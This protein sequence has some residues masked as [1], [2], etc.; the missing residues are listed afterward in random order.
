MVSDGRHG[1]D[2]VH[3]TF[4]TDQ[5]DP[6]LDIVDTVAELEGVDP[7]EL[8]SIY[9]CIDHVVDHVF[10]N[11]PAPDAHVQV[12]FSYEGYRITLEQ[13]GTAV[14]NPEASGAD[15]ST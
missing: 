6:A 14:F 4:D 12:S 3:V 7:T 2:T 13:D 5:S 8:S 11:P 9:D 15:A 1:D 10:S